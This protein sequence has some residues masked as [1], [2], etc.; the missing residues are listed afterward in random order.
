MKTIATAA[1]LL[2]T[3]AMSGQASAAQ[4]ALP[5]GGF[6]PLDANEGDYFGVPCKTERGLRNVMADLGFTHVLLGVVNEDYHRVQGKADQGGVTYFFVMN[7]CT[8]KLIA[9][10]PV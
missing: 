9:T 8:G 3:L 10:N 4:R 6:E 2:L 1:A 7:S 5:W